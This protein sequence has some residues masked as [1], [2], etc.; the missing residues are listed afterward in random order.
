MSLF[1]T[2]EG[3]GRIP[4]GALLLGALSLGAASS[5]SFAAPPADQDETGFGSST[6][7][8]AVD[9]LVEI[10]QRAPVTGLRP[11]A[12]RD[13]RRS[14]LAIVVDGVE[15]PIVD[16]D[17]GAAAGP[18]HA[19]EAWQ[20]VLYM[21][22][23]LH[24]GHELQWAANLWSQSLEKLLAVGSVD[25]I[26]ADPEP[27][28]IQRADG[29]PESLAAALARL[30]LEAE[31]DGR[32]LEM[33]EEHLSLHTG[34]G[35][36]PDPHQD[37]H[38]IQDDDDLLPEDFLRA[39]ISLVQHRLETLLLTLTSR[40]SPG[41]RK[42]LLWAGG[43]FSLSP[44]S[45]YQLESSAS[46]AF[47]R[48]TTDTLRTLAAYGWI[49]IPMARP[50]PENRARI[51]PGVRIGKL[52]INF[53]NDLNLPG[54]TVTLEEERDAEKADA[55]RALAEA[56]LNQG[57]QGE[58][59]VELRKALHHYYG[60]PRTADRQAKAYTLLGDLLTEMGQEDAARRAHEAARELTRG[61]PGSRRKTLAPTD[62]IAD[63]EALDDRPAGAAEIDPTVA[64]ERIAEATTGTSV[65]NARDLEKALEALPWRQRVTFQIEGPAQ[66]R[67]LSV[68]LKSLR[69]GLQARSS[70]W[71]RHGTP[72]TLAV[73]R[74][75]AALLGELPP[76]AEELVANV[77]R[78]EGENETR[79][80]VP[81]GEAWKESQRLRLTAARAGLDGVIQVESSRLEGVGLETD[82]LLF[83]LRLN[84]E[85]PFLAVILEDLATGRW[86]LR[87]VDQ[88]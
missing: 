64:F 63:S 70:A 82:P 62:S 83:P 71:T 87:L 79:L 13:L 75:R 28:V 18:G 27:R 47:E 32:L 2:R 38:A 81:R 35:A 26:V 45:F 30:S 22:T 59:I 65:R 25:L 15:R 42:V 40:P 67:L 21:D 16:L 37:R 76:G 36:G 43:A 6:E 74:A 31:G 7:V 86:A 80:A 54:F 52:R 23:T 73:A 85:Q 4:L 19:Q 5:S 50:L 24:D 48:A 14:D 78:G 77:R 29:E 39:E 88:D 51:K 9:L 57:K 58:A 49:V 11:S 17:L 34:S 41:P 46:E 61:D 72:D 20:V 68:E 8:T 56:L 55:H 84:P 60:D 33:R 3:H 12:P 66:A 69:K 1:I 53:G 44:E 10:T